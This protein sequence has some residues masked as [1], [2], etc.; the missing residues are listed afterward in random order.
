M[1][2][3]I[4]IKALSGQPKKLEKIQLNKLKEKRKKKKEQKLLKIYEMP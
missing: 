1:Y 4:K 2:V 3:K